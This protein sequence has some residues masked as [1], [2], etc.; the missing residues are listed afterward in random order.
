MRAL[1]KTG[2]A[3]GLELLDVPAPTGGPGRRLGQGG[4]D[5]HLRDRPAHR[6]LGRMGAAVGAA[7]GHRRARVLRGGDRGRIVGHR[8]RGGGPG[9]RRGAPGV[10][11]LPQLPSRP[12]APVHQHP[13]HR[14]PARRRLRRVRVAAR[15]QRLGAPASD[16]PGLDVAAIFDP[17]G[18]A[19]HTALAFP[20]LGEDVLVTGAGPIGIMAA[21]VAKHAG[22]RHVVITDVSTRT[23]GPGREARGRPGGRH[24]YRESRRR[25]AGAA[26]ERGLRRRAGDVGQPGRPA[27]H[28]RADDPRRPDRGARA[29][30][31]PRSA[32]TSRP[33]CSTC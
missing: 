6:G 33:S 32:S 23:A 25:P 13:R 9:Q 26:D 31:R 10:R 24:P 12:P 30:G 17:F 4:R 20:M 5:R 22:A 8:G 21:M 2:P 29:A 28:D 18:N 27:R 7:A 15:R 16:S 11:S 3:P 1:V 19:V 14:G